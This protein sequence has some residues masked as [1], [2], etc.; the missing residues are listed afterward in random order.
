MYCRTRSV[1]S[2]NHNGLALLIAVTINFGHFRNRTLVILRHWR[3][4]A[5]ARVHFFDTLIVIFLAQATNWL[6]RSRALAG[7]P[8][9]SLRQLCLYVC[10]RAGHV[11]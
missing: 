3:I 11:R 5:F 1:I 4:P 7:V 8:A 9:P 10:S 6:L 2:G